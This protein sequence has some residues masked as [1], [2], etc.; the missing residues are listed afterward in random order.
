LFPPAWQGSTPVFIVFPAFELNSPMLRRFLDKL[1]KH[2]GP[3]QSPSAFLALGDS[4]ISDCFPGKGLGV[5]SLLH[6]NDDAQFPHWTGRDLNA[7]F[8]G[9]TRLGA[10]RTG[11]CLEDV[12]RAEKA[13]AP[14]VR[15]EVG[16]LSVGGNDMMRDSERLDDVWFSEFSARYGQLVQRLRR[17]CPR[18][19]ICNIYDPTDGNGVLPGRESRGFPPLTEL[20]AALARL[21]AVIATHAGA[22]LVDIHGRCLGHGWR[23]NQ[24]DSPHYRA[25]DPSLWFQMD[26]EPNILGASRLREFLWEKLTA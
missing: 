23:H 18:W 12:E 20:T 8:P 25:D 10:T 14:G 21:N 1:S 5:A 9:V 13:V 15:I 4:I 3:G 17:L 7:L 24:P 16:L 26:I 6:R 11:F 19:L 22:D 2:L